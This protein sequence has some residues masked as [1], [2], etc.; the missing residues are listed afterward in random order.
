[1]QTV[2]STK[3]GVAFHSPPGAAAPDAR[4]ASALKNAVPR[5][6]SETDPRYREAHNE[7][8]SVLDTPY[9]GVHSSECGQEERRRFSR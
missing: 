1:M 4:G 2:Y 9:P 7:Y 3:A 8:Q 5:A 6:T